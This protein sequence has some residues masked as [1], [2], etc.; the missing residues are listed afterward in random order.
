M[1]QDDQATIRD[2]KPSNGG[3]APPAYDA[4][5]IAFAPDQYGLDGNAAVG[6]H[7]VRAKDRAERKPAM[8]DGIAW[9]VD[10]V[11]I[12]QSAFG[13]MGLEQRTIFIPESGEQSVSVTCRRSR[14]STA[15]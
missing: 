3:N 14:H 11:A 5:E 1:F 6:L 13:K 12:G 7:H 10:D 4:V 15:P 2:D 9:F 8:P